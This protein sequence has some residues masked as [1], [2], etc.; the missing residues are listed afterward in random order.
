MNVN[1]MP[2]ESDPASLVVYS[3]MGFFNVEL[4][5]TLIH[6]V[7]TRADESLRITPNNEGIC[8]VAVVINALEAHMGLYP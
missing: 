5:G 7:P 8:A 4:E 6:T 3:S 2:A 1:P